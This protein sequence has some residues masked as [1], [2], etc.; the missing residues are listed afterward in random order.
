[1]GA[2]ARGNTDDVTKLFRGVGNPPKR[3]GIRRTKPSPAPDQDHL[4]A[5]Q[6]LGRRRG[7]KDMSIRPERD[8]RD[9]RPVQRGME[10]LRLNAKRDELCLKKEGLLQV[11]REQYN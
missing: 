3:A 4:A 9:S 1:M 2:I 7:S 5:E 10:C 11:R 6:S 8:H